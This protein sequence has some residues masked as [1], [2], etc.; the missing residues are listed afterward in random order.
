MAAAETGELIS[1][2]ISKMKEKEEMAVVAEVGAMMME[3]V[4]EAAITGVEEETTRTCLL[5][6]LIEE[7]EDVVAEEEID[8]Q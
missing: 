1:N 7:A 4:V 3:E 5:H 6:N 2:P 8:L